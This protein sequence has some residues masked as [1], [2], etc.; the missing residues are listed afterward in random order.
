MPPNTY[1]EFVN[2]HGTRPPEQVFK[3]T[4]SDLRNE[5]RDYIL[6]QINQAEMNTSSS[7]KNKFRILYPVYMKLLSAVE[8][9]N[10]R[11]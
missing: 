1:A 3:L 7:G 4:S 8:S 9:N 2:K 5:I 10:Y 6:K 11:E